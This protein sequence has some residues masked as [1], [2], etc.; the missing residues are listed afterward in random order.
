MR[1]EVQIGH[2]SPGPGV[3]RARSNEKCQVLFVF[4][5]I[6]FFKFPL[7]NKMLEKMVKLQLSLVPKFDEG[8]YG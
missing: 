2:S 4:F 1:G 8:G 7:T 3:L 5:T 6:K